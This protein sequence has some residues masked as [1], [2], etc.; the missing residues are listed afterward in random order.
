MKIPR[1]TDEQVEKVIAAAASPVVIL[2]EAID[3]LGWRLNRFIA[4]FVADEFMDKVIFI[5]CLVDENPEAAAR[6]GNGSRAGVTAYHRNRFAGCI[7]DTI[8]TEQARHF[9]QDLVDQHVPRLFPPA[10]GTL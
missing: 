5:S 7:A 4:E 2:W 6:M 1:C 3:S 10:E 9:C 8:N